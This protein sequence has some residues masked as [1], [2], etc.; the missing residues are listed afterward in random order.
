MLGSI[1]PLATMQPSVK[2]Q[3]KAEGLLG[4][5]A[6]HG[7]SDRQ[8]R[9][10]MR[11]LG[12]HAIGRQALTEAR[13]KHWDRVMTTIDIDTLDGGNW[14]WPHVPPWPAPQLRG[15]GIAELAA[16]VQ[17]CAPHPPLQSRSALEPGRRLRRVRAR[18][19]IA[20]AALAQDNELVLLV[21]GARCR[22]SRP[23]N[24]TGTFPYHFCNWCRS[25][26]FR[27]RKFSAP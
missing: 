16:A 25:M 9:S 2:R 1:D 19:Q 13:R 27:P 17:G 26:F 12:A 22:P 7:V 11:S 8:I 23:K 18:Q 20:A 5:A 15:C 24:R 21:H 3:K 6:C 4:S 10:V 14:S